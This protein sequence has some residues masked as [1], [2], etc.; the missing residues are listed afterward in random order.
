MKLFNFVRNDSHY[1]RFVGITN[2]IT[3]YPSPITASPPPVTVFDQKT[4]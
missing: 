2:Y 4:N 1:Y 3:N